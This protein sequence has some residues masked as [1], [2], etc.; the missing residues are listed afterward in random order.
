[1]DE[2]LPLIADLFRWS[3]DWGA[4]A[5]CTALSVLLFVAHRPS[6][7]MLLGDLP[8]LCLA[9]GGLNVVMLAALAVLLA[10]L[11]LLPH[12]A[13]W[14]A[15]IVLPAAVPCIIL[16]AATVGMWWMAPT[17]QSL[18][19]GSLPMLPPFPL[20]A[21]VGTAAAWVAQSLL[22]TYWIV[23]YGI[24]SLLLLD[25]C[26]LAVRFGILKVSAATSVSSAS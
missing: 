3:L 22:R 16:I 25:G 6:R 26:V 9:A 10:P 23:S 12:R 2:P 19:D 1:M 17:F 7:K 4:L 13:Q 15:L 14:V 20:R 11:G 18:R 5:A 21:L 8:I 24:W